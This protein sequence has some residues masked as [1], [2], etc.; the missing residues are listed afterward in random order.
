MSFSPKALKQVE[1]EHYWW[2]WEEIFDYNGY[3]YQYID[4]E[5]KA[6]YRAF[7]NGVEPMR[8]IENEFL[9]MA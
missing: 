9:K 6:D 4:D 5:K 2:S 3:W 8:D 1:Q 7:L